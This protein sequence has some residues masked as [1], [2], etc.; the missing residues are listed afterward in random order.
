MVGAPNE[1]W[2]SA[3]PLG[4]VLSGKALRIH[5]EI[6]LTVFCRMWDVSVSCIENDDANVLM[7]EAVHC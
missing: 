2:N 7:L 3:W 4:Y 6:A 1:I 5:M